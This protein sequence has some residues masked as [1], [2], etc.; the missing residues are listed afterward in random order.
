MDAISSSRIQGFDRWGVTE[1]TPKALTSTRT[2]SQGI[3]KIMSSMPSNL[4]G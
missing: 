3:M 1:N 4:D 2:R